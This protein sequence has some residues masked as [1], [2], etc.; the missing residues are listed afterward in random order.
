MATI[1]A[2]PYCDFALTVMASRRDQSTPDS[3]EAVRVAN[4]QRIID[5]MGDLGWDIQPDHYLFTPRGPIAT[6]FHSDAEPIERMMAIIRVLNLELERAL[7]Y[8]NVQPVTGMNGPQREWK[9]EILNGLLMK[10]MP[11]VARMA[12]LIGQEAVSSLEKNGGGI[13]KLCSGKR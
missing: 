1:L 12:D 2:I 13:I 3:H 10:V 6:F 9:E 4:I 8:V 7:A 5:Q 11:G